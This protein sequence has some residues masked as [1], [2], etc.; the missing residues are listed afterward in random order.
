[1][2]IGTGQ[3]DG[4]A[5]MVKRLPLL[6]TQAH[7]ACARRI[8]AA[9]ATGE[10]PVVHQPEGAEKQVRE[11]IVEAERLGLPDLADAAR[12]QLDLYLAR[13]MKGPLT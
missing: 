4:D 11:A 3:P 6:L 7:A 10:L 8:E 12:E 2:L 13:R 5:S 9:L 1:M